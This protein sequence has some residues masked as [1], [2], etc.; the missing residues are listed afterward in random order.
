VKHVPKAN[1]TLDSPHTD[2][3]RYVKSGAK[4]AVC[5]SRD[6]LATIRRTK[7]IDRNLEETLNLL[8]GDA[9]DLVFLEGFR[10]LVSERRD[11]PKIVTAKNLE[12]LKDALR[13]ITPPVLAAVGR[14]KDQTVFR[15][16]PLLDPERDGD[17]LLRMVEGCLRRSPSRK[18]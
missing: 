14:F 5:V 7:T 8:R 13:K 18:S 11:V 9:V 3:W 16:I 10:Y 12:D 2:T 17:K 4:V 6:E 15:G 1:F